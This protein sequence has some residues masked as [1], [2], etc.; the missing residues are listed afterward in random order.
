MEAKTN[1]VVAWGFGQASN[2]EVGGDGGL[3]SS[4]NNFSVSNLGIGTVKSFFFFWFFTK[5]KC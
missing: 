1:L 5:L 3:A 4:V 2:F